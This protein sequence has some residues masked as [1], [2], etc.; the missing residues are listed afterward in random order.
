MNEHEARLLII[1]RIRDVLVD[2]ADDGTEP[3]EVIEE[4]MI[5]LM[6]AAEL[7]YDSVGIRVTGGSNGV[8][9]A[10]IVLEDDPL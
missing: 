8:I 4:L 10:N 1:Q 5:S 9:Q 2:L 6:D 3:P 7:I